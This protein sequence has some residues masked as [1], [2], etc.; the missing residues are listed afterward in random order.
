[1]CP[2][3]Y[4]RL[5]FAEKSTLID[6]ADDYLQRT[7]LKGA[8]QLFPEPLLFHLGRMAHMSVSC[9]S[10][11][12]CEDACPVDIPV[13]RIFSLVG[14]AT[15]GIFDY[16]PGSEQELPLKRFELE[17]LTEIEDK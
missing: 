16:I 10:C 7:D 5:C 13:G 2:I 14:E 8:M 6:T 1:V 17:E 4:C 12:M 11:G 3:C 15:Q 9:V